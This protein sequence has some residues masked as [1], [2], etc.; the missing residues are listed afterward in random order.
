MNEKEFEKLLQERENND[1]DF[2]LELPEHEKIARLVV[3]FS[4]KEEIARLYREG[5]SKSQ[6][7]YPVENATLDDIDLDKIREYFKE[8][9]LTTQLG[10]DHFYELLKKENFVAGENKNLVPTIAGILLFG[11]YPSVN[12]SNVVMKVDRY[13]GSTV[14]EWID[15]QDLEGTIF[16]QIEDCTRFFKRNMKIAAWSAETHT[17]HKTEYPID[18]LKEAVIN[19]LSHRDWNERKNIL[20]RMFDDRIE[21]ISPGELLRPLTIEKLRSHSY[22]PESRNK[23]ITKVLARRKLMDERGT[24]ILRMERFMDGWGLE[25]PIYTEED[26]YFVITFKG[27]GTPEILI[28]RSKFEELNE[29]QKTAIEYIKK[30]GRITNREYRKLFN[31]VKD[32]AL[33]DIMNLID[34]GIIT[35]NY[36]LKVAD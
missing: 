15:K 36:L 35:K 12:M 10:E 17:E 11:K 21:I 22:K 2:K 28:P 1:L 6:D 20:I 23:I 33:R 13:K 32:T 29:R 26:G 19:A 30:K 5:S 9:K 25:K 24:G 3:A 16:E 14:T 4:N 8:S 34:N 7:V 27:P 18:A 31:I